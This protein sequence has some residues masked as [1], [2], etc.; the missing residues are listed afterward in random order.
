[1]RRIGEKRNA[2]MIF[3]GKLKDRDHLEELGV[4]SRKILECVFKKQCGV[5]GLDVSGS[6]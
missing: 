3:G 5:H 6:G 4:D 2:Y 1:V